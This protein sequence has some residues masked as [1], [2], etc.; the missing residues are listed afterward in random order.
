MTA[1]IVDKAP[2][3]DEAYPAMCPKGSSAKAF[4]L[5]KINPK[6]KKLAI[7]KIEN[8]RS[9][10]LIRKKLKRKLR[11]HQIIK[12]VVK[13]SDIFTAPTFITNLEFKKDERPSIEATAAK[14][15]GK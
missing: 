3:T 6:K 5:P 4:K 9:S 2:I 14:K 13:I 10:S 11:T 1:I 12:I 8:Q 15:R 7:I